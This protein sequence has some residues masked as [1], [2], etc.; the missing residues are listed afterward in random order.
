MN[1]GILVVIS[2]L[3][4]PHFPDLIPAVSSVLR[5]G[6]LHNCRRGGDAIPGRSPAAPTAY[7]STRMLLRKYSQYGSELCGLPSRHP[8]NAGGLCPNIYPRW[9]LRVR[10][11]RASPCDDD[12]HSVKQPQASGQAD[13]LCK[14]SAQAT[15]TIFAACDH[16]GRRARLVSR[17]D[18]A[19]TSLPQL[20]RPESPGG[21]CPI[22]FLGVS[23]NHT[24]L[25]DELRGGAQT[26]S[27][28]AVG[29]RR[30]RIM[31][32]PPARSRERKRATTTRK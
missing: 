4:P 16:A 30:E 26:I 1:T 12:P 27:G 6:F 5:H 19:A 21:S 11:S 31:T 23:S 28:R 3:L 8:P 15:S 2:S 25:L 18:C 29:Q 10:L 24:R 7:L 32:S 14:L 9:S 13:A 17:H 20:G 22:I